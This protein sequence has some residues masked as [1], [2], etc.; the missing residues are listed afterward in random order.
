[1][2]ACAL[3][4][5]RGARR[6]GARTPCAGREVHDRA[7]RKVVSHTVDFLPAALMSV[8]RQPQVISGILVGSHHWWGKGVWHCMMK[9]K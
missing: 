1:M 4:T 7:V 2:R 6:G 3:H 8:L 5:V 9:K